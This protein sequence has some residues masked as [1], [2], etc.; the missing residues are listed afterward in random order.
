MRVTP[1]QQ[2]FCD[3]AQWVLALSADAQ[4]NRQAALNILQQLAGREGRYQV[5]AERLIGIWK[6]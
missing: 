2:P 3:Q 5:A 4:G 6:E 1:N